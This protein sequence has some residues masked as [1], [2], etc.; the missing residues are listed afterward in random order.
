MITLK[1]LMI[2]ELSLAIFFGLLIGLGLTG[3]FYFLKQNQKESLNNNQVLIT[4]PTP[5]SSTNK[6]SPSPA[7]NSNST[8]TITSPQNNDIVATSKITLKGLSNNPTA[9]LI[10]T[11]PNKNY[12]STTATDGTFTQDID[13]DPGLNDLQITLINAQDQEIHTEL[14]I[15]YSTAKL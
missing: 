9:N 14:F 11:T 3:T 1:Q 2:K 15:T 5:M 8:L 13:L 4:T 10:I 6:L 12:H 7:I